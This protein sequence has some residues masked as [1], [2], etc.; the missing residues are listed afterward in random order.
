MALDVTSIKSLL[1][2]NSCVN[3]YY[4]A[5][6][7]GLD[8]HVLLHVLHSLRTVPDTCSFELSAIHVNHN[9]QSRSDDWVAHCENI[10]TELDIPLHIHSVNLDNSAGHSLEAY[11]RDARQ[12]VYEK[13]L[14]TDT[15]AVLLAHH[16]NDQAETL[17]Q[18]LLR[19]AGVAGLSGMPLNR[20]IS[21]MASNAEQLKGQLS[22]QLIRPLLHTTQADILDY[23][24]QHKLQWVDDP[25]NADTKFERNYLRHDVLPHIYTQWP[26]AHITLQRVAEHQAEA[27]ALLEDLARID[28]AVIEHDSTSL[29]ITQLQ[30][31]ELARQKNV[32]RYW[33]KHCA[34]VTLPETKQLKRIIDEVIQAKPD[35][36]PEF[37]WAANRLCRYQDKIFLLSNVADVPA[38]EL[39]QSWD[40]AQP[41]IW[42]VSQ[43]T[44]KQVVG[45][46]VSLAKLANA[47]LVVNNR[48]GGE[49]CRPVGNAHTR[50]LKSLLQEWH[51][52]PWQRSEIPLLYVDGT[53]VQVVGYCICDGF[54]AGP[55]ELGVVIE[56]SL[57][58]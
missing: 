40:L 24:Q 12:T 45:K 29:N 54:Q 17:L 35:A 9:L 23:A 4:V 56:A 3:H 22:G 25:S 51:V 30:D 31:L 33:F 48:Q 34:Y 11:A 32:L 49:S 46:G 37:V 39:R 27:T 18:Q 8:S 41:L 47:T 1:E 13:Y 38:C 2:A 36:M 21:N 5:Y 19:G 14:L 58:S 6:S 53:L 52:P 42:G 55:T 26:S 44:S 16:A 15:S 28:L 57:R 50:T 43:L 7:G 10:C 20:N